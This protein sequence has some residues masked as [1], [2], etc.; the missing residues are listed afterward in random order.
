MIVVKMGESG[1][2]KGEK[3][4]KKEIWKRALPDSSDSQRWMRKSQTRFANKLLN[5]LKEEEKIGF[6]L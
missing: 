3:W 4:F 5:L 6:H 1:A 2:W